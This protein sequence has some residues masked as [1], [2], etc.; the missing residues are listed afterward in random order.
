[1]AVANSL[2]AVQAG[3]RQ[4]ECTINGIGERAGNASLEEIV[5]ALHVRRDRFGFDTAIR[6]PAAAPRPAALLSEI[7]RRAGPAEQGHRRRQR[8]RARGG[9]PSGRRP[10]EPADLRDS[11]AGRRRRRRARAGRSASTRARA[12]SMR[13]AARWASPCV[14]TRWR[15][16]T[17]GWS[18][19]A[20]TVKTIEDYHIIEAVAAESADASGAASVRLKIAVLPGDGIGP[21]V[22]AQAVRV[23]QLVAEAC[24]HEFELEAHPIGGDALRRAWHGPSR[25]DTRRHVWRA[26][27]CCSAPSAIPRSITSSRPAPGGRRCL[28]LRRALG[29]FANLRPARTLPAL[30]EATPYR[31]ERVAGA[32]VLDR[33]RAAGRAVFRPATRAECD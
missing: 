3:A 10:E 32:D 28:A 12:A 23:L 27:R 29:G 5:M 22:T 1:M 2:A 25:R 14:P 30:V 31:P 24:G 21:E 17:R 6:T 15:A 8:V 7:G 13:A 18:R 16:S 19:P 20:D 26:T 11:A 9:H 33:P 4:V